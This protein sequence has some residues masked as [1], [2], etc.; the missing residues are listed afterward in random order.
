MT[1]LSAW[2]RREWLSLILGAAVVVLILNCLMAPRGVG[3][4]LVLRAHG[5]DLEARV[6]RIRTENS[7]LGTRVQKLRSDDHYLQQMIRTEL[8]FA[9]PDE[10]VYRFAPG[11][12]ER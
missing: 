4:L 5:M 11:G 9:R 8:G 3:D 1:R 12:A 6:K 7:D 2:L 10:L